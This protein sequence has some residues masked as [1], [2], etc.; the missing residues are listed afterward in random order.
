MNKVIIGILV[1][2]GIVLTG[3]Y[4]GGKPDG[5]VATTT[6]PESTTTPAT[7]AMTLPETTD[8]RPE[9]TTVS[10]TTTIPTTTTSI[11]GE[12]TRD[13]D[14]IITGNFNQT[15][16]IDG[17]KTRDDVWKE[18][19]KCLK[20]ATCSC[21]GGECR[22]KTG[23]EY[24]GCMLELFPDYCTSDSDCIPEQC[25]HPDSCVNKK[26][27]QD[28]S[29]TACTAECRKGTMDCGCG[30]CACIDGRCMVLWRRDRTCR[31][32]VVRVL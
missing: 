14:C 31:D 2:L 18:E 28:C 10:S 6:I 4:F 3:V 23:K 26:F 30:K 27:E 11:R 25:C 15:C 13:R 19:Y 21:I 29:G 32:I 24:D 22:W 17:F 8:V 9:T 12:C 20:K 7:T 5:P 1:V 16:A